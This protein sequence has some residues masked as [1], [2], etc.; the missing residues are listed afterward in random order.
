MNRLLRILAG[1]LMVALLLSACNSVPTATGQSL[2]TTVTPI[3]GK[4]ESPTTDPPPPPVTEPTLP[5]IALPGQQI[6]YPV[7]QGHQDIDLLAELGDERGELTEISRYGNH[8]LLSF[9]QA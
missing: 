3:P 4:T 5:E 7:W 1:G 9:A 8:L 2:A 6:S